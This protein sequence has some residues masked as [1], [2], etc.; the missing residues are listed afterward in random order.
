MTGPMYALALRDAAPMPY[1]DFSDLEIA[2]LETA[3]RISWLEAKA[4]QTE[5]GV[6]FSTCN[7]EEISS[8]LF[9]VMAVLANRSAG[10][11]KGLL[12]HF[13]VPTAEATLRSFADP[14]PPTVRGA[15]TTLSKRRPDFAFRRKRTPEGVSKP[16]CAAF[17]E[18]KIL[19]PGKTFRWYTYTGLLRFVTGAYASSMAQGLLLGY[20]RGDVPLALPSN[21]NKYLSRTKVSLEL[22]VK[23][24]AKLC[25]FSKDIIYLHNSVHDR[26]WLYEGTKQAPGAVKVF[27]LWLHV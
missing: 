7:E 10:P 20:V 24:L 18:A 21:L 2:A 4:A 19:E 22:K 13:D 17:V 6:D 8:V 3:L 11:L 1:Q 23:H 12:D 15:G 9:E 27:H 25:P 26:A 5:F 16:Y 14:R